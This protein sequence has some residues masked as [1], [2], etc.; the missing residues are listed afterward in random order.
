MNGCHRHGYRLKGQ[1]T[2]DQFLHDGDQDHHVQKLNIQWIAGLD[3]GIHFLITFQKGG[4]QEIDEHIDDGL[5]G[6]TEQN[7]PGRPGEGHGRYAQF[8]YGIFLPQPEGDS[9]HKD[10]DQTGDQIQRVHVV[11]GGRR[12]LLGAGLTGGHYVFTT[13]SPAEVDR[14]LEA[15]Q[16]GSPLGDK[17]RRI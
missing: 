12:D 7:A 17:V 16:K 5:Q 6:N 4:G 13:E 2:E 8:L 14:I 15:Y 3:Q 9:Q 11:R 1:G 10:G